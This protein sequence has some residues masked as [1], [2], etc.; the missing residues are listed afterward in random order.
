[1]A[2]NLSLVTASVTISFNICGGRIWSAFATNWGV[3]GGEAGVATV[4]GE[5]IRN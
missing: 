5:L 1:M 4:D 2:V 3:G